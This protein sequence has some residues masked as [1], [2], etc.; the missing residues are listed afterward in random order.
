MSERSPRSGMHTSLV[1]ALPAALMPAKG[2]G[3]CRQ[4]TACSCQAVSDR[5]IL[6][7]A[8]GLHANSKEQL[9]MDAHRQL[10]LGLVLLEYLQRDQRRWLRK[11]A[12]L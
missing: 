2:L 9:G 6:P 10:I 4:R 7:N 8:G 1:T 11:P 3:A 12:G 5:S